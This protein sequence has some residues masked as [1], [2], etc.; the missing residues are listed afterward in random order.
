MS[1]E[2]STSSTNQAITPQVIAKTSDL[3]VSDLTTAHMIGI[4]AAVF[5]ILLFVIIIIY[6]YRNR[7]EGTYTI[8]E[9]K[10][11]GPFAELNVPL[12]GSKESKKTSKSRGIPVENKEWYV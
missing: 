6:K 12:N 11:F 7:E 8:D 9:S 2:Q 4:I 1:N 5:L 10:N 3:M